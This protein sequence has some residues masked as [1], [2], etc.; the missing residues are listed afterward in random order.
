MNDRLESW[1]EIA[2]YLGRDART[3]RRWEKNEGLPVQRHFHGQRSTVFAFPREIDAW[4]A[5]RSPEAAENGRLKRLASL[6]KNKKLLGGTAIAAGFL[7]LLGSPAWM[8]PDWF[9]PRR[10][11]PQPLTKLSIAL[12]ETRGLAQTRTIG[13]A[14]SPDGRRIV[15]LGKNGSSTQL[16]LRPLDE[17]KAK[18]IPGTEGAAGF[19]FFSPDGQSLGFFADGELKRLS[20]NGG[21][22]ITLCYAGAGWMGGSWNSQDTIVF[23][24]G[25]MYGDKALYRVS[26]R[27]G[28]REV[29]AM[30]DA[31]KGE[32][33]FTCPKFLPGGKELFFD[34]HNGD[35]RTDVR[36][37][38]LDTGE[39]RMVAADGVNAYY[40]ATGHLVYQR[41]KVLLAAPFDLARLDVTG[42]AAP[43]MEDIRGV[44]YALS[45]DGTLVYAAGAEF[46]R[47]S[48]VWVNQEGAELKVTEEKRFYVHA[49]ISPDGRQIATSVIER[50]GADVWVYD[51]ESDSFA[52]LTDEVKRSQSPLWSP[53][54]HWITFE[55]NARGEERANLF[56]LYRKRTD[57]SSG[58]EHL[59][60]SQSLLLPSSWSPDGNALALVQG[61][62]WDWDVQGQPPWGNFDVSILL[63]KDGATPQPFL[64]SP[65]DEW[66]PQFSPNGRWIAYLS[67]ETGSLSL[68]VRAYPKTDDKWLVLQGDMLA[69]PPVWSPDG[70]ELFYYD[71]KRKK[72]MA[73]S[74]QMEPE[75][76]ASQ[77]RV[78]FEGSYSRHFDIS[79]D[80]Q[81]FL[82]IKT[83]IEP[84]LIH[85]VLNWLEE[86]DRLVPRG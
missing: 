9:S 85:V 43:V 51:L 30:P 8:K 82:M 27:G 4:L 68:Y 10:S 72:M 7:V 12:P 25:P 48:L 44:D 13:L 79:P 65:R 31:E 71:D 74:V 55:S 24:A 28:E 53:D 73:V 46:P 70:S 47:S 38:S 52:R 64:S 84:S 80:G 18:P 21:P 41:E 58:V 42:N 1:K 76:K 81:R 2:A 45:A 23:S 17:A 29:V 20:F 26:A 61:Q 16:Y 5:K 78:V 19:P 34:A 75:F 14:V 49:R 69:S 56:H 40:A 66:A 37:L 11:A 15:Y 6:F 63:K 39:Q 54:G 33:S 57:G 62:P 50:N 60:T 83:E 3:V 59:T 36:V 32:R 22:Q 67:G 86:L 77:P 35:N